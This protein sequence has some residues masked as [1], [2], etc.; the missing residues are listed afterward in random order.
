MQKKILT[1]FIFGLL[2]ATAFTQ[3]GFSKAQEVA[4]SV[5]VLNLGKYEI[6]TGAFTVDFYLSMKCESDCSSINFE[7]VN[8]RANSVDKI[9]DLPNEKFYR[10]QANL[11]SPVDLKRFPFDSQK[12]QILIEDKTKTVNEI[13]YVADSESTGF[14]DSISFSGWNIDGWNSFVRSHDYNVY[15]ETYSQYVFEVNISRI[16]FNSFLKTFLPVFFILMVV[17]VSFLLDPDKITTRLAMAGASLTGAVMFHIS[18]ANQIP[19][20]GYL[21]FADKFMILTYGILM[22]TFVINVVLL[23]LT[24]QKKTHLVE[25]IHRQTEYL[26][27]IIAPILYILLFVFF[28]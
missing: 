7:F 13:I 1:Y 16:A 11:A 15:G 24:E 28:I 6:S 9:I 17:L 22:T 26:M 14:D 2:L 3:A 27:F 20:V 10:I 18:I 25:K 21:T 5:Y 12:I 8:G 19:P 4:V 23:E